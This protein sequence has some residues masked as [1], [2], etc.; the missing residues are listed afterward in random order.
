MT[1]SNSDTEELLEKIAAKRNFE[2]DGKLEVA[3]G[4]VPNPDVVSAR[5]LELIPLKKRQQEGIVAGQGVFV[6]ENGYFQNPTAQEK[7]FLKPLYEPVDI[8]RYAIAEQPTKRI[9]YSTR[10]NT[11]QTP[12]PIRLM[13]HLERYREIMEERRENQTGRL[14]FFQ[15]HWPR[16]ERFF[17]RGEKILAV[18]KCDVPIFTYT[19]EDA[20]V[21]MAFNVIKT[22]RANLLYLTGLLNS[23]LVRFWLRHRGKMQ[24]QNF[25][26]DKEPLLAI[27]L[28]IPSKAE[29]EKLA[30][31]VQRIID[32]K[33]QMPNAKTDAEKE[34]LLRLINQFENQI[35][36]TIEMTVY[37]LNE[38]DRKLLEQA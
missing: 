3:Q 37:E 15:L 17:E 33:K 16:D 13:R 30:K 20:Y 7:R 29:Q 12:L 14:E 34:Q 6:I 36:D 28:C 11:E 25:Q 19:N 31:S 22:D 5:S 26:V 38:E 23:R 24:G 21:M 10:A 35:Q 8:D 9:I 1:F 32:C 4:I 2:L 27:P 18:R